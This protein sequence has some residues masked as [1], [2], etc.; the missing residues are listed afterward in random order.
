MCIVLDTNCWGVFFQQHEDM[1]PVRRWLDKHGGRVVYSPTPK[2]EEEFIRAGGRRKFRALYQAGQVKQV[3]P[4]QVEKRQRAL[5]R[6]RCDDP[7]IIA[8]ALAAG[9]NVLVSQDRALHRDFKQIVNGWVYQKPRH[10]HLLASGMC[11]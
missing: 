11:R 1:L 9:V 8:L 3:P 5:P 7:H 10:K 4:N 2:L 6:L